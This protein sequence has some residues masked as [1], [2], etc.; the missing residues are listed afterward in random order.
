MMGHHQ[1][2]Y[3]RFG[4]GFTTA[5]RDRQSEQSAPTPNSSS[6]TAAQLPGSAK[7][8]KD[9]AKPTA[10]KD[11]QDGLIFTSVS[12]IYVTTTRSVAISRTPSLPSQPGSQRKK[13]NNERS[14][15]LIRYWPTFFNPLVE[16][17]ASGAVFLFG[18]RAPDSIII[19]RRLS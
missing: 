18:S 8:Y 15:K 2:T 4:S 19:K 12:L 1:H 10:C 7:F 14:P 11:D 17:K 13:I 5:P 9:C 6:A 3:V 16:Q